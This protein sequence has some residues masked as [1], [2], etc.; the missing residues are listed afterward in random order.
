MYPIAAW[1]ILVHIFLGYI[2]DDRKVLS[3]CFCRLP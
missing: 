2:V 3:V 1:C